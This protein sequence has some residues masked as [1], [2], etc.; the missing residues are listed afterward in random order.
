MHFARFDL[1]QEMEIFKTSPLSL[2]YV[3]DKVQFHL[4]QLTT[5][6]RHP[7]TMDL[8]QVDIQQKFSQAI[9]KMTKSNLNYWDT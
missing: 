5:E 4:H 8:S 2:D 9:G 6:Q 7:K 1:L 3:Q